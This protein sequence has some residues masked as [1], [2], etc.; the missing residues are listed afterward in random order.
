MGQTLS[1]SEFLGWIARGGFLA[2][3]AGVGVAALHGSKTV[4]E[5]F[6]ENHCAACWAYSG[7]ALPEKIDVVQLSTPQV[8][9]S[10]NEENPR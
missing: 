3:L 9:R 8:T 7:C 6:N 5:C 4:E 1:R 10:V 2:G